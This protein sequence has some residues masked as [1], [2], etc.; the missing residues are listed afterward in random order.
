MRVGVLGGGVSGVATATYLRQAGVQDVVIF[1]QRD[2]LGGMAHTISVDGRHFDIGANYLTPYYKET[3]RLAKQVGLETHV[4]PARRSFDRST[5]NY[6]STFASIS[7]G[8]SKTGLAIGTVW[9]YLQ[10]CKYRKWIAQPGLTGLKALPELHMPFG[11]WLDSNGR[12]GLR[13]MFVIPIEVFGY[14]NLDE[15]PTPYVLKYMTLRSFTTALMVGLGINTGWPK[16]FDLGYQALFDRLAGLYEVD[17]RLNSKVAKIERDDRITV[18]LNDFSTEVFDQLVVACPPSI[19]LSLLKPPSAEEDVLLRRIRY[20]KYWVTAYRAT[21]MP[22]HLIDEIQVPPSVRLPP[23]GHPWGV[24]KMWPDK[25]VVL[26]YNVV[27]EGMT[28]ERIGQLNAEDTNR[29][30]GVL[31]E[32]IQQAKWE[33]YFPHVTSRDIANG[34]FE[35]VDALQGSNRTWYTGGA[36][37]TETVEPILQYSKALAN[38]IVAS[39]TNS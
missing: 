31:G 27:Q 17:V 8:V 9:Y 10:L 15:V 16:Q 20:R 4:S 21:G 11:A 29:M 12:S 32:P 19:A 28:P 14:G 2:R 1:E 25:D 6:H 35:E 30:G 33:Y 22:N 26:Y 39:G 13:S 38:R 24:S 5:G 7:R 37:A 34:W 36:M 23:A 3:L 18:E